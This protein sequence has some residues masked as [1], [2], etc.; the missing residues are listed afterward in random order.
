MIF[1]S[2]GKHLESLNDIYR[3][4]GLCCHLPGKVQIF[5][6][7][8][9]FSTSFSHDLNFAHYSHFI[10]VSVVSTRAIDLAIMDSAGVTLNK[11]F[12]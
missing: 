7:A 9:M 6:K 10:D 11:V 3:I 8:E 12:Y 2:P 4:V 5:S 1:W